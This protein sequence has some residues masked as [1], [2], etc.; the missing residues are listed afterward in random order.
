MA[1]RRQHPPGHPVIAFGTR[2]ARPQRR[3]GSCPDRIVG[4]DHRA[5]GDTVLLGDDLFHLPGRR[6]CPATLMI[7]SIFAHDAHFIVKCPASP[8]SYQPGN[9]A[10]FFANPARLFHRCGRRRGPEARG[11]RRSR[12]HPGHRPAI[13]TQGL[14]FTPEPEPALLR[15]RR[16]SP[17]GLPPLG[18]PSWSATSGRSP[19]ARSV[20]QARRSYPGIGAFAGQEDHPAIAGAD[21]NEQLCL[22]SSL[23]TRADRGG[24][25]EEATPWRFITARRCRDRGCRSAPSN[26]T[27]VARRPAAGHRRYSCGPRPSPRRWP[28][29]TDRPHR[30]HRCWPLTRPAPPRARRSRAPRL[31]RAGRSRGIKDIERIVGGQIGTRWHRIA[32]GFGA[33]RGPVDIARD[34]QRGAYLLTLEQH[35][36]VNLMVR[37]RRF[38]DHR[39]V[40][41]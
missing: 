41:K 36:M 6:R 5:F 13:F 32:G 39:F 4:A 22:G 3:S 20:P 9:A 37:Q 1:D 29:R 25:G 23:R 11:S 16:K 14:R 2:T 17:K 7:S 8:V 38:I 27:V 26:S 18:Q 40:W 15:L 21:F 28:P 24:G 10:K 33:Q 34:L 12:F 31:G 19:A 30:S 35:H